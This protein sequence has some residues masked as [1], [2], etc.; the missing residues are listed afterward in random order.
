MEDQYQVVAR[1]QVICGCHVHV[2]IADPDVAV[3]TMSR[4][5]PWLPVLLALSANS[6]FWS[7]T[8]TGYDSYRLEVWERWPTAGVPPDL[9]DRAAY[10]EVV[11][12]LRTGGAI[13]DA[14]HLYWY[15]R[16]SDRWPTLEFRAMDVCL[17][18]DTA[19]AVAGLARALVRTEIAAAERGGPPSTPP[20][21]WSAPPSGE[22]PATGWTNDLVSPTPASRD[23]RRRSSPSC[24]TSWATRS[25]RPA[26]GRR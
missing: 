23:R 5:R 16:P 1:Q 3:A 25:T 24:W 18:V 6:P 17:D 22:R 15:L 13:E 26:T 12:E 2:G 21:R 20:R 14:T 11:D 4:V 10:D 9:A 7:G 19:V 8:D